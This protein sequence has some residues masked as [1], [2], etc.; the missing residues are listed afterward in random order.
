MIVAKKSSNP[1][2]FTVME[3]LVALFIFTGS[4]T[5]I[6]QLMLVG[7]RLNARRTGMSYATMLASNQ[8]ETIRRQVEYPTILGDSTY[9]ATMNGINF[10]IQR[11]RISPKDLPPP[12]S[13]VNYLEF[14]VMVKRKGDDMSY[15]NY[16]LLQGLHEQ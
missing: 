7:D 13:I 3:V 2:G 15:V 5:A 8:I 12:D 14:S 10:I 4:V 1:A 16:H 11:V 9:E 6:M